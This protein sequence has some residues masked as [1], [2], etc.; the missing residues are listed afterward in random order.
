MIRRRFLWGLILVSAM[1]GVVSCSGGGG[2][3]GSGS[4][5]FGFGASGFGFFNKFGNTTAPPTSDD[6]PVLIGINLPIILYFNLPIDPSTCNNLSI[7]V[8]TIDDP[9]GYAQYGAGHS[10][11][12]DYVVQGTNLLITP[13]IFYHQTKVTYGFLPNAVYEIKFQLPPSPNVVRSRTGRPISIKDQGTPIAFRTTEDIY[14]NI[15]GPPV[16]TFTLYDGTTG[17]EIPF[18]STVPV[19]PTPRIRIDFDEPV[20]PETVVNFADKTSPAISVFYN[21]GGNPNYPVKA[22]G[23]WNLYQDE[24]ESYVEFDFDLIALL[25]SQPSQDPTEYFVVVR[26]TVADLSGMTKI[27]WE[28]LQGNPNYL[29]AKDEESFY[30]ELD[31]GAPLAPVV[32]EFDNTVYED[33]ETTSAIWGVDIGSEYG[34]VPGLGGG[35]G[36]DGA[37]NPSDPSK[38]PPDAVVDDVLQ[39]VELPT[40]DGS[41]DLRVY[42][43]TT[44]RVPY[45]W[46]LYPLRQIPEYGHPLVIKAT[47]AVKIDGTVDLSPKTG[48]HNGGIGTYGDVVGKMGGVGIAGGCNGGDGGTAGSFPFGTITGFDPP[49][50]NFGFTGVNGGVD[51]YSIFDPTMDFSLIPEVEGLYLQPNIGMGEGNEIVVTNHPTFIVERVDAVNTS[52]LWIYSDPSD[53]NYRGSMLEASSNPGLP[54]PPITKTGDPYLLADMEG[55]PG[56]DNSDMD[57]GGLGS[58]PMSVAQT[59]VTYASAGGGGGGGGLDA[60]TAGTTGPDF[61]PVGGSV[62]GFSTPDSLGAAAGSGVGPTGSVI[63][64]VDDDTIQ[65]DVDFGTTDYTDYRINPNVTEDGWLFK[66]VGN[67]SDTVDVELVSNGVDTF[68]LFDSGA[69]AGKTFK[70]YPPEAIGGGGGGGAGIECTG[71]LKTSSSPY[72]LPGW[73]VGAGGGAGGGVLMVETAR[74]IHVST[75]GRIYAEG[76]DGGY[77]SGLSLSI[78]GGGGG[79]GGQILFRAKDTIKFSIDS[80]VSVLG[81]T[82]GSID[83]PGGDGGDGFIRLENFSDNLKVS[84]YSTTTFPTVTEENLG[85]F[86]SQA[87]ISLA[88]SKFYFTGVSRPDFF[89]DETGVQVVYDMDVDGVTGTYTYPDPGGPYP[90]PPLFTLTFN[91]APADPDGFLDLTQIDDNFVDYTNLD[92]FDGNPYFR[93]KM[94]LSTEVEEF[95]VVYNKLAVRSISVYRGQLFN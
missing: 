79:G 85:V 16:P 71:T 37:F 91:S 73:I 95:G 2:G 19:Q 14:D 3:S 49:Y 54:P 92:S 31:T 94:M 68:D 47:G 53:P 18:G 63:T 30:T 62:G 13:R 81:G 5:A 75:S 25:P 1:L 76:G 50:A 34:L 56:D 61:P 90:V 12:V 8:T 82:G 11:S 83:V 10:A 4:S 9:F 22:L 21:R 64:V 42:N 59:V 77:I 29:D 52:R 44:F 48:T 84:S 60:G 32:E 7:S 87:E 27:E 46:T 35:T 43:F 26:G 74:E 86:P 28:R 80:V 51:D 36:A 78:P 89:P 67:T 41:G 45:G 88:Q 17:L 58:E 6:F 39:I 15:P 66:I 93:F 70:L 33:T 24:N 23:E 38:V 55:K 20:I 57:R 69:G 72:Q 40:A 65:L